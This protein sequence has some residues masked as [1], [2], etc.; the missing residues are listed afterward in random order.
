MIKSFTEIKAW[1]KA[2]QLVLEVYKITKTFPEIEKYCLVSQIRRAAIS[3]PSN[4]AEGFK[5]KSIK[6]SEHFYNIADGSLEEVKYQLIL[7]KDLGY[8]SIESFSFIFNLTEEAGKT[9]SCWIK[10]QRL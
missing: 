7:A 6:D 2:H 1:E 10:S 4:I 8:I 3:I 5:R 9:L